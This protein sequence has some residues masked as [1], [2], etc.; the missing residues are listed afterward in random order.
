MFDVG[1]LIRGFNIFNGD[2][3]GK[4]IWNIAI[5]LLV[6]AVVGL[7]LWK[8]FIAPTNTQHQKAQTITNITQTKEDT[9]FLGIKIGTAKLGLRL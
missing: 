4:L 5:T 8:L 6:I 1:K 9:F 7:V 3:L 2:V